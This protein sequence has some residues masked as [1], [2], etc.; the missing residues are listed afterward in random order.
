MF[1]CLS[2]TKMFILS[3]CN[4]CWM[5]LKRKQMMRKRKI[6]TRMFLFK[7]NPYSILIV[8]KFNFHNFK[9]LM[10][11]FCQAFII[12][13]PLLD[14]EI[15]RLQGKGQFL[16]LL[17]RNSSPTHHQ[18]FHCQ[19]IQ[20]QWIVIFPPFHLYLYKRN[21]IYIVALFCTTLRMKL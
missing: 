3:F 19:N 1:F 5:F 13:I 17:T 7:R 6:T 21:A 2:W 15:G 12:N 16:F 8:S 10:W 20:R 4:C 11:S 14:I 9:Y 18:I